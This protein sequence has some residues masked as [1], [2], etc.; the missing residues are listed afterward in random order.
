MLYMTVTPMSVFL[1]LK[2]SLLLNIKTT[3]PP[4]ALVLILAVYLTNYKT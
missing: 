3:S 1:T 4:V 2:A